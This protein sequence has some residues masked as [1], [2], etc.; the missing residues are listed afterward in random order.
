MPD[1]QPWPSAPRSFPGRVLAV[2]TDSE[3]DILLSGPALR[4]IR[5]HVDRLDLLV[6]PSGEA[7]ARLLPEVDRILVHDVPWAGNPAPP[8]A[9]E[10]LDALL[11]DICRGDYDE[12]VIFSSYHQS[13]LP[14]ALIARWAGVARI[15]GT[16]DAFPGTLL[17]VRHR[18]FGTAD[19]PG[20]GGEHEVLAMCEQVVAA[21][22]PAVPEDTHLM[23]RPVPASPLG[24][25]YLVVHPG[26]SVPS[27]GIGQDRAA[28]HAAAL[29]DEG[30]LVVVTGSAQERELGK[31]VTPPSGID[32]TGLTSFEEL[33][34]VIQGA[35]A[36]VVG[37]TGPAHLAAA[38][39]TPVVSIFSPVVPLERW[40]P[41]G[42]PSVILGDQGADCRLTRASTCPVPGH[43]CA[44]VP[45]TA[46]IYAVRLL[47]Q[48]TQEQASAHV[49]LEAVE[50]RAR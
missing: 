19:D 48:S 42:V 40:R 43:P 34:S 28:R 30:W 47:T 36:I 44:D 15:Q 4:L 11:E 17:D 20:E 14:M 23:I 18:R 5:P 9:P 37:N 24:S 31:A 32:L 35:A 13:P 41:W 38:V 10:R 2:R 49:T 8:A 25:D 6:S 16:S 39:G 33:A 21:G 50:G 7:A 1:D 45:P 29:A 3:G 22:Y 46:V 26:A 12:V 27:R